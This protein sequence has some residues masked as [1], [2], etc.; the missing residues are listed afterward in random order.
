[1]KFYFTNHS[2]NLLPRD[3]ILIYYDELFSKEESSNYLTDL[4]N[5]INWKQD[6]L[7][8]FGRKI[9]TTRK[10]AWY[11]D[12]EFSYIYSNREK[13]ALPWT[14]TILEIKKKVE[15]FS[16]ETFN[17]CLL[18]LYPSGKEGMAYHSDNESSILKHSCIA[19]I[20]FGAERKFFFKHN[21]TGEK[22]SLFLE[23]G[24]ILLMKGEIQ[25]NWKHSLPKM[26]KVST[27]RVNLTF[28]KMI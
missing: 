22:I 20:S 28:R 5:T 23:N 6:E 3:G 18:N 4:L 15:N 2:K 24:S 9:I 7:I 16:S 26:S 17:S 19:S 27:P 1:M 8:I 21:L 14:D 25:T 10:V 13:K 11:G 12:K